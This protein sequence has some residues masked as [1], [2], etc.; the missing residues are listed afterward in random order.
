LGYWQFHRCDRDGSSCQAVSLDRSSEVSAAMGRPR[1]NSNA[2]TRYRA[3]KSLGE[4]NE[5]RRGLRS[6]LRFGTADEIQGSESEESSRKSWR[7]LALVPDQGNGA[8]LDGSA[9]LS[10]PSSASIQ[11]LAPA[12]ARWCASASFTK[13]SRSMNRC[14]RRPPSSPRILTRARYF[15]SSVLVVS[16]EN[17]YPLYVCCWPTAAPGLSERSAIAPV[18]ERS[19]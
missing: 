19:P 7:A 14:D 13:V 18:N 12:S 11:L 4:M 10:W 1:R 2:H 9:N 6:P 17:A 15:P 8:K 3:S 16:S 5:L